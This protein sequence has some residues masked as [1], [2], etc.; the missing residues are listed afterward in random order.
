MMLS[1]W[2]ITFNH[3]EFIAGAIESV[4]MQNTNFTFELIIG[5]DCSADRTRKIVKAYKEACPDRIR[6]FL[7]DKNLGMTAMG[8]ATYELCTGRYVAR[9]DGDDLWTDP[10]KLQKQV[11]FLEANPDFSF[12]FHRVSRLDLMANTLLD[13]VDPL[14]KHPDDSLTTEHFLKKHNPVY[15]SSI[16]YRNVVGPLPNWFYSLPWP[17]WSFYFFL[18]NHGK[19]KYLKENMGCYRIHR[20]AVYSGE[21]EYVNNLKT[22]LFFKLL[23]R[24]AGNLNKKS[25]RQ[26]IAQLYYQLF[27]TD[28][29]TAAFRAAVVHFF[30]L[31]YYQPGLALQHR[32][33]LFKSLLKLALRYPLGLYQSY[34][35]G[36]SL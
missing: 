4:L 18:L 19:A 26:T 23:K 28:G 36:K 14:Y 16:V 15:T 13:S 6:L 21:T 24:H 33:F 32:Q 17:D 2:M 31:A 7:P 3:E 22:I 29:T 8:K 11:D 30:F 5:E 10:Y 25:I 20:D 35:K 12:C 1:V 9:L 34:S 27:K